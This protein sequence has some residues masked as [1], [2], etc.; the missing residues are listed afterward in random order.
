MKNKGCFTRKVSVK[1]YSLT[2]KGEE[3]L[4]MLKHYINLI[5]NHITMNIDN[6]HENIEN[7]YGYYFTTE[8]FYLISEFYKGEDLNYLLQYRNCKFSYKQKLSVAIQ[9]ANALYFLHSLETPIVHNNV[10]SSSVIFVENM[11][12]A[13]VESFTAKLTDLGFSKYLSHDASEKNDNSVGILIDNRPSE[14]LNSFSSEALLGEKASTKTDVYFFGILLFEIFT[15]KITFRKIRDI[16]DAIFY[17]Q[18]E[19]DFEKI[20]SNLKDEVEN[21]I[22]DSTPKSLTELISLC[23]EKEPQKRPDI[24]QIKEMLEQMYTEY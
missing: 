7:I 15:G 21:L 4:Q 24:A 13:N 16:K 3:E 12:D 23:W 6:E 20:M 2:N 17:K 22:P 5:D 11:H 10:L 8:K 9:V 14:P 1:E 19:F 18:K